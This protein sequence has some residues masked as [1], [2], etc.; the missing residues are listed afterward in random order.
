MLKKYLLIFLGVLSW[1]VT[2]VK[3][4]WLYG[5]GVGYWGANA[6]DGIWHIALAESLSRGSFGMPIFSGLALQNYHIGFDLILAV[7][8]RLTGISIG[9]LYFQILP[10]VL[11]LLIGVLT[12][13]FV[14]LWQKSEVKAFWATFFVFFGG[15]FAWLF[16][17]GE[18]AF[19]S[20]Q[21]VSTLINP[22]FAL[23]LVSIL[24]AMII[25]VKKKKTWLDYVLLVVIL[26]TLM[27]V[28][29]YAGVLVLGGV[30]TA[31]LYSAYFFKKFNTFFVFL[32]ALVLTVL[33][34]LPLNAKSAGLIKWQPF[35]FLESMVA[36]SDRF[37]WPKMA[38]AMISYKTQKV[39][40][41]FIPAYLSVLAIF[42]LGNFGTRLVFLFR[43]IKKIT[44]LDVFIYSIIAAGIIIPTLFVQEGTAWNTIQFIYY[45]L[46]F[47]G[48]I[49]GVFLGD[50][51]EKIKNTNLRLAGGVML[52]LIT[53]PTT[54][55]SLKDIYL[56]GRPPAMLSREEF[57]A[58]KY[59]KSQPQGIVL[60]YPYDD[61]SQIVRTYP[62]KPLFLYTSTAYVSA[63]S[64]KDV[65][66]EDIGSLDITSFNWPERLDKVKSWYKESDM[67][68]ARKFLRDSE[69]KYVYWIK[70]QRA[71]L[72]EGQ[73]GLK[74]IFE[75]SEVIIY[76]VEQPQY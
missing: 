71:Y 7:L 51:A 16:G 61:A 20:Q 26:G 38:E 23:S 66:I 36:G 3:S 33:L 19:W 50:F 70:G 69:I 68:L 5:F 55:V 9:T 32:S 63:Y 35:W 13:K 74:N 17:K 52:I 72:G 34:Y 22:P 15:S 75:N 12:Y 53:I 73:L 39:I 56:P 47:S 11:A 59:L 18:S 43:K 64:A 37:Y 48:I 60:T 25:F 2:M 14:T 65:Y 62:P 42:V 21:S 31:S 4:G 27:E 41:K 29:A 76:R 28:K 46:F 67:N 45:S 24:L 54:F 6:H 8:D 57:E 58:L 44:E 49:A 10:P 40:L 30:L 1:S